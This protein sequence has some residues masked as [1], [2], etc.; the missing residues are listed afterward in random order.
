MDLQDST[1]LM[2]VKR[3]WPRCGK[4]GLRRGGE[5]GGV[6]DAGIGSQQLWP[7]CEVPG[8][9]NP[10]RSAQIRR[11]ASA[12]PGIF[13]CQLRQALARSAGTCPIEGAVGFFYFFRIADV[14]IFQEWG[15]WV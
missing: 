3:S 4:G 11:Q 12:Q 1:F 9:L 7:G 6:P 14:L 2:A 13:G 10:G 15:A 8:R 5:G